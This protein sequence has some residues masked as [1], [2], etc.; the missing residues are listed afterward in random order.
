LFLK[1]NDGGSEMKA[2]KTGALLLGAALMT[3][4]MTAATADDVGKREYSNNCV[5]CHGVSGK[6]DGPYAG[7]ISTKIADLT[8]LQKANGG[9]FPFNRVYEMIDG[10][11][12]VPAHGSRDM[13][14][15]G[16]EYNDKAAEYYM[17][18]PREFNTAGFIRG[19]ILALVNYIYELQEK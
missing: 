12:A 7:I 8:T 18:Y 4:A 15:W 11:E 2:F 10:R 3:T 16:N 6:G 19:R 9:V 5:A 1:E 17:D 14:I 13:P